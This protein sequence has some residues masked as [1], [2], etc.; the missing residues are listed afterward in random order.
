[1]GINDKYCISNC[2]QPLRQEVQEHRVTS[3]T[4]LHCLVS[5]TSILENVV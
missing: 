1:M 2:R 5:L 4:V 3:F